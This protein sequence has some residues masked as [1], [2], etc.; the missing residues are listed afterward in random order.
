MIQLERKGQKAKAILKA[1][2]ILKHEELL[3]NLYPPAP[4]KAKI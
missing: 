1:I 2:E 4:K 3:E